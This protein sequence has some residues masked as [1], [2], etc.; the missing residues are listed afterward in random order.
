MATAHPVAATKKDMVCALEPEPPVLLAL[1]VK[2]DDRDSG[3]TP[4]S[5]E[6]SGEAREDKMAT[7]SD[8]TLFQSVDYMSTPFAIHWSLAG[9]TKSVDTMYSNSFSVGK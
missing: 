8:D 2:K 6:H 3:S 5:G 9:V 4:A 7:T 1:V